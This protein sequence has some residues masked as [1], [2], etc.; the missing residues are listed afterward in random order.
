MEGLSD[1]VNELGKWSRSKGE[2]KCQKSH[3]SHQLPL[4]IKRRLII[5]RGWVSEAEENDE[6]KQEKP[7]RVIENGDKGHE[8]DGE[9]EY[10]PALLSKE[11]IGNV[12]SV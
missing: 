2:D 4:P 3:S 10:S 9:E 11:G 6:D 12:A 7:S 5:Q 1:L 8:G